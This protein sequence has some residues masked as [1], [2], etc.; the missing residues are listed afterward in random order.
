MEDDRA[1][2]SPS[3]SIV[4][5]SPRRAQRSTS[6][7]WANTASIEPRPGLESLHLGPSNMRFAVEMLRNP[8]SPA[9]DALDIVLRRMH[10]NAEHTSASSTSRIQHGLRRA[11]IDQADPGE[12]TDATSQ[13]YSEAV[14]ALGQHWSP[15]RNINRAH[16]NAERITVSRPGS[17]DLSRFDLVAPRVRSLQR[18]DSNPIL[19]SQHPTPL[20]VPT[21][22]QESQ[23]RAWRAY[24]MAT[25]QRLR[26][27]AR[28]VNFV[29]G[30]DEPAR[31]VKLSRHSEIGGVYV[32]YE[33]V[34]T[35]PW[36]NEERRIAS[37]KWAEFDWRQSSSDQ[38]VLGQRRHARMA[39][40]V[41]QCSRIGLERADI[42]V[43]FELRLA[44]Q[45]GLISASVADDLWA[46]WIGE[47][48][49][50]DVMP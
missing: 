8:L 50:D 9:D 31:G 27:I 14:R 5:P 40:N 6:L 34:V 48:R 16:N 43:A 24:S 49:V 28:P 15:R 46:S 17:P 10:E 44:Q 25:M 41:R 36:R 26:N 37:D 1:P 13:A 42:L 47:E 4:E 33:R 29:L 45:R 23:R 21:A 22:T 20:D 38:F 3:Y 19:E 18:G 39:V 32:K 11:F 7:P 2:W 30:H 35:L 12:P